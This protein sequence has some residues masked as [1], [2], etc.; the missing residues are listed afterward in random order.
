[1][2]IASELLTV[3]G[4]PRF[5]LVVARQL[6]IWVSSI[7]EHFVCFWALS[8]WLHWNRL[9]HQ[10]LW[11]GL[12]LW[13]LQSSSRRV[14]RWV[15]GADGSVVMRKVLDRDLGLFCLWSSLDILPS[16]NWSLCVHLDQN[17]VIE[18]QVLTASFID[19]LLSHVN[20]SLVKAL[21]EVLIK[22]QFLSDRTKHSIHALCGSFL[23]HFLRICLA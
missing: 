1:M 19:T 17:V 4:M 9:H 18:R 12:H 11:L 7:T 21:V 20:H 14:N 22:R 8:K 23:R 3:S 2:N 16:G 5:K 6:Q 13:A 15:V 10:F